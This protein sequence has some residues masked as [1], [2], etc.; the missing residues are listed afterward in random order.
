MALASK[1]NAVGWQLFVDYINIS[2]SSIP[3]IYYIRPA[4]AA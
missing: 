2:E 1:N 3:F 4:E